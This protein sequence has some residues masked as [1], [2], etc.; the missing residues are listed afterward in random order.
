MSDKE[1]ITPRYPLPAS[2]GEALCLLAD[3]LPLPGVVWALGGSVAQRL[4]GFDVVP[5]D[6]DV[7]VPEEHE[8]VVARALASYQVSLPHHTDARGWLSK[9]GHYEVCGARV[10][11]CVDCEIRAGDSHY[12]GRFSRFRDRIAFFPLGDQRLPV[13]PLEES[14]LVSVLME[15]WEKLREI[16]ASPAFEPNFD[17]AYFRHRAAETSV[18]QKALDRFLSLVLQADANVTPLRLRKDW[19]SDVRP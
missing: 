7:D 6:I 10:D 1:G 13:I 17:A 3:T 5:Q 9:M 14:L 4:R 11:I 12:V 16:T 8:C 18:P 15:R 19:P 2:I